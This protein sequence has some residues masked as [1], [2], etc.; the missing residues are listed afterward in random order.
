MCIF[1]LNNN[2]KGEIIEVLK[3]EYNSPLIICGFSGKTNIGLMITGYL[4]EQMHMHEVA[5]VKSRDIPPVTVFVGGKMRSPFRIYSDD[6]GKILVVQSEVPIGNEGLYNL[7]EVLVSFFKKISS[8]EVVVME[9]VPYEG[10]PEDTKSYIVASPERIKSLEGK[11]DPAEA[12]I[13]SGMGGAIINQCI[14]ENIESVAILTPMSISLPDP[15]ALLASI[16]ALNDIYNLNIN[17]D[18]I[19]ENVKKMHEEIDK[20]KNEYYAKNKDSETQDS[21]YR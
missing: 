11:I 6:S 19:E 14:M 5:M 15:V 12:A 3:H 2:F 1:V 9:G 18:I 10:I 8:K 13:I 4:I 21:M 7:S 17:E 16:N 20:I